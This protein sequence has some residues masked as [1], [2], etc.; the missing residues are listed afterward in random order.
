MERDERL[1]R[2][3][4]LFDGGRYF[5]AHEV[6]EEVWHRERGES[7]T[8]LQ[9]LIQIAA[10]LHKAGLGQPRGC[11]RLLEAGLS[12][13]TGNGPGPQLRRFADALEKTLE[14][15]RGWERGETEGPGEIPALGPWRG[16]DFV[17]RS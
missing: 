15:A 6:W 11:V 17:G 12:K 1:E 2:G 10:A 5:E 4:A 13:L 9:G 14:R 16:G 8:A 7:R 3:R